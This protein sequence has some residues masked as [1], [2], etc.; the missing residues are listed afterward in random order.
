MIGK[1]SE[2]SPH[3][4]DEQQ[5][6]DRQIS[7]TWNAQYQEEYQA[8]L[9]RLLVKFNE[10]EMMVGS[11]IE[12]IIIQLGA[13]HLYRQEDYLIQKIDQLELALFTR[14]TWPRPDFNRLR[15]I[16]AQRNDL[17]HGHF[18]QNPNT[19]GFETRP[20]HKSGKKSA[21]KIIEP[22]TIDKYTADTIHALRDVDRL[23]PYAAFDDK[24]AVLPPGEIACP[25]E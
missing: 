13:P 7:M 19:G 6:A 1:P 3:Y 15:R 24:P 4:F 17:A 23:G 11:I 21:P 9:G 2:D 22:K 8:S 14:P 10:L 20:V 16:N 18:H 25:V 12:Q 5:E